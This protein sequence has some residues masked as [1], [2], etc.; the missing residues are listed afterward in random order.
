MLDVFEHLGVCFFGI[1]QPIFSLRWSVHFIIFNSFSDSWQT[2]SINKITWLQFVICFNRQKWGTLIYFR[3]KNETISPNR[4]IWFEMDALNVN[5]FNC[6]VDFDSRASTLIQWA[7]SNTCWL[8]L[9]NEKPKSSAFFAIPIIF[10]FYQTAKN[11]NTV[12]N[13]F[14][15]EKWNG[16]YAWGVW[17]PSNT[18]V[19]KDKSAFRSIESAIQ[20]RISSIFPENIE[21]KVTNEIFW[22]LIFAVITMKSNKTLNNDFLLNL[23]P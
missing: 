15:L 18:L 3:T 13:G 4:W 11:S 16:S 19:K 22:A 14:K 7:T 6:V 8:N 10:V 5:I 9:A 2:C 17:Y 12:E 20:S 23:F 1:N 21:S